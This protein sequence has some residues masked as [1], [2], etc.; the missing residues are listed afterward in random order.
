[1]IQN[2][3]SWDRGVDLVGICNG[4]E[5][6]NVIVH[7]AKMVHTPVGSAPS[8]MILFQPDPGAAPEVMGFISSDPAV[9]AYFGPAI[10][11][12]TPFENAPVLEA[13]ISVE[14][15]EGSVTSIVE[16]AGKTIVCVLSELGAV[17]KIDRAP[18]G[19]SPFHQQGL[20]AAAATA[21]LEIDGVVI[22]LVVP[23]IG[24]TGGP[25]AVFRPLG[26]I[27]DRERSFPTGVPLCHLPMSVGNGGR[28]C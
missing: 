20:E 3:M 19:M 8:G 24:I 1:M 25:G 6:P 16:V 22:D 18:G 7:V 9:G 23:P 21:W 2:Y 10:F 26:S 11:A 27:Q 15:K 17:E 4:A 14:E 13:S 12:G 5:Q 28:C